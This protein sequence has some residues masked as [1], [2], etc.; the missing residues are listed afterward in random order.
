MKMTGDIFI[1]K[2]K[3]VWQAYMMTLNKK[4]GMWMEELL[5][6]TVI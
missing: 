5:M 4:C 6:Q 3:Y 2:I 1:R